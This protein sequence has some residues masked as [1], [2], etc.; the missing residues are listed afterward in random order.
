MKANWSLILSS[1]KRGE[2]GLEL[3]LCQFRNFKIVVQ[4]VWFEEFVMILHYAPR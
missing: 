4:V 1:G 3:G 2:D